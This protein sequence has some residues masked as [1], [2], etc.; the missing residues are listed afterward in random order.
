MT[1]A[2]L[3]VILMFMKAL[4]RSLVILIVALSFLAAGVPAK[5]APACKM[6]CCAKAEAAGT[7]SSG[8]HGPMG[9]CKIK[10]VAAS[11][12]VTLNTGVEEFNNYLTVS[13]D[14]TAPSYASF[15]RE[16]P[17][18]DFGRWAFESPPIYKL[19]KTYLC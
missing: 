6:P 1:T 8:M 13:L 14:E 17:R 2:F 19:T 9:C 10:G 7:S 16:T 12:S 3:S 5:S 4:S 15:I 18:P 11:E